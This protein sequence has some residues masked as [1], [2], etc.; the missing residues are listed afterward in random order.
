M[1]E[2]I[3]VESVTWR[4]GKQML[5][6]FLYHKTV[7]NDNKHYDQNYQKNCPKNQSV[8]KKLGQE[9]QNEEEGVVN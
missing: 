7:I 2:Y 5:P 1:A 4:S 6:T 8:P 9:T 3:A